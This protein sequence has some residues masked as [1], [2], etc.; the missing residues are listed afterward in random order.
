MMFKKYP[1]LSLLVALVLYWFS[2]QPSAAHWADLAT[3]EFLVQEQT[4]TV[5]LALPTPLLAFADTNKDDRIDVAEL[6][7]QQQQMQS[8]LADRLVLTDDQGRPGTLTLQPQVQVANL[9]KANAQESHT[10]LQLSYRW[11]GE[12]SGL[13]IR[14][15]LFPPAV[16]T[17]Q[18][19]ATITVG[20]Q[21]Q[22]YVFTPNQPSFNLSDQ[23]FVAQV[24]RFGALGIEH[25]LTGYD[26]LLFLLSLLIGSQGW[27]SLVKIVTA[28]TLAHSITLSLATLNLIQLAPIWVESAI[29]LSIAYVAAENLWRKEP[30]NRP[31]LTFAFGLIHGVGFASILQEFQ[32]STGALATSLVSFNLGVEI[33]QLGMV[34]VF[35]GLLKLLQ[36]QSWAGMVQKLLSVALLLTGLWWFGQRITGQG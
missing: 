22:E 5:N 11:P 35:Y 4:V 7:T 12:R 15:T 28:F 16:A 1:W 26:H 8:F 21:V 6:R 18:S 30:R 20:D 25:I 27:R 2:A 10:A 13:Q 36:K 17:A 14:Y 9:P 24:L 23:G 29:A 19:L 32:L 3:A 34:A 31:L 33:G